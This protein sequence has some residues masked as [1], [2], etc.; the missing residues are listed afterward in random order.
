MDNVFKDIVDKLKDSQSI[1][2][3][4]FAYLLERGDKDDTEY[5]FASA[6]EVAG[7]YFL[8]EVYLRGLIEFSNYCKN[9]C[10]Y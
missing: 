5:L 2:K 4:D 6:R 9:D 3:E 10:Y 1:S 7:Q 8:K